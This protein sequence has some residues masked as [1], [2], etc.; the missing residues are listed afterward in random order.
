MPVVN[1]NLVEG[2]TEEQKRQIVKGIT[3]V[4][5]KEAEAKPESVTIIFNDLKGHDLG[6][7]YDLFKDL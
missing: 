4:L 6:K 1:V 3:E 7:G 5:V 2:R